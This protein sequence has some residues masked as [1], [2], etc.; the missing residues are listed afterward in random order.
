V[1][2][3]LSQSSILVFAV[4]C[5]VVFAAGGSVP[6]DL[7]SA[8]R[9]FRHIEANGRLA[10]P[11]PAPTVLTEQQVNA[12]LASDQIQMPAG[13]QSVKL[14]A[15]PG[16]INGT[17]RID[18]DRVRAGIHSSNPLL[19]VFSGVHDVEVNTHAHGSGGQGYVHVDSISLDA[20]EVPNFI[21]QLFVEK[22]LQPKYPEIGID[23]Q[24]KLPDRIDSA[25]VGEHQ[26][27]L[28]Q[29]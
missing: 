8:E 3:R 19:S 25:V 26:I 14:H 17:A 23:S 27:T 24:F 6:A 22:Y 4:V 9:A 16:V 15:Q 5:A 28:V 20:I 18:F 7:A 2:S 13:V 11:N 12:Y 1:R 29:R 10:H 21:L